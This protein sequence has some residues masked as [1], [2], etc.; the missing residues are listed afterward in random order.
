MSRSF[1]SS[2]IAAAGAALLAAACG[3]EHMT[4]APPEHIRFPHA[5]LTVLDLATPDG[6]GQTVHPDHVATFAPW[7]AAPEYLAATPYTFGDAGV[8]N[9]SL[10]A[11]VSDVSWP[12]PA[13]LRNPVV[14]PSA[15]YL[16]DPDIVY[17]PER[18]ELWLYHRAVTS[19][20]EIRLV[21]SRD[22]VRWSEP[23]LVVAAPN[24]DV[25]SPA[26]V[27]RGP[28]EWLMWSVSS[29]VG[30]TA[31]STTVE[32]RRSSDGVVFGPPEPVALAQPGWF[33]W[34]IDVQW[35]PSRAEYWALYA[36]K[37]AGNCTTPAIYLATSADGMTWTTHP[38]PVLA[39]G[40]VEALRDVVYRSTFA[41]DA[42]TDGIRFWYSGARWENGAYVW[43]T[44][45]HQ[46]TRAEVFATIDDGSTRGTVPPA[47]DVPPLLDGP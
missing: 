29:N 12:A 44:V 37:D 33:V 47:W 13:G 16:S 17:V 39:R 21:T 23:A 45:F 4:V 31:A 6:S 22:G 42:A 18:G 19:R 35:I 9:P 2:R 11:R 27:R 43:H 8:E 30:C 3:A 10:Y 46:R 25:V 41:Y 5:E 40:E 34:H 7:T 38:S 24:H 20:N 15:G 36:V 28:T 1:T 26:V 14:V 32:V